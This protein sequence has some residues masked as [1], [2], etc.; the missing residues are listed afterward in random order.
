MKKI[1]WTMLLGPG[2]LMVT[3]LEGKERGRGGLEGL[4]AVISLAFWTLVIL[5]A[6]IAV[7]IGLSR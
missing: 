2:Q 3:I 1:L 6:G 4:A 7:I 5:W